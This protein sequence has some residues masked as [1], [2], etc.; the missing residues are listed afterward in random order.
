M[1]FIYRPSFPRTNKSVCV[2]APTIEYFNADGLKDFLYT[3]QKIQNG[4]LQRF[5]VPKGS[6]N[7]MIR[8]IWTPKMCLLERKTN[9]RRLHDVRYGLYERAVT[10]D[11]ADAYSNPDPVRGSILPGDIQYLCEQIVDHVMEVS[12]HK[13][14]ISRM[15]LHLK[16]DS[17]DKVWFLWSSSVRLAHAAASSTDASKPVDINSDAH[18]PSFVHLNI[19]P[20]GK[21]QAKL[22]HFTSCR[23]CGT[24]IESSVASTVTYKAILE[25]F[26]QLL[27]A[28]KVD[29]LRRPGP[30]AAMLWPPD[31]RIIVAAGGV[32]FGSVQERGMTSATSSAATRRPTIAK[33]ITEADVTIPPMLRSLHPHLTVDEFARFSHDPVF[34]YKTTAVCTDCFL[35]FADYSTSALEVNTLRQEAPA[36]LRPQREIPPLKQGTPRKH[37]PDSAWMPHKVP[38]APCNN[39][40]SSMAKSQYTFKT[41]PSLPQRIDH[42]TLDHV[43]RHLPPEVL[44]SSMSA[45]S[46][47]LPAAETTASHPA[48]AA[49]YIP[50]AWRQPTTM[51]PNPL[52]AL[53]S[54]KAL[55]TTSKED[56]FFAE[57]SASSM[58]LSQHH[59]LRHMVD[60]ASKL[61]T[62][63]SAIPSFT[64][65]SCSPTTDVGGPRK[66]AGPNPYAVV[67]TLRDDSDGSSLAKKAHK[68]PSRTSSTANI[69]FQRIAPTEDERV[70]SQKHREFLLQS[71]REIQEQMAS[72]DTLADVLYGT[73]KDTT[74]RRNLGTPD[75]K[76]SLSTQPEQVADL[77][78]ASPRATDEPERATDLATISCD[79]S[80]GMDDERDRPNTCDYTACHGHVDSARR[81]L[82]EQE[83]RDDGMTIPTTGVLTHRASTPQDEGFLSSRRTSDTHL[84]G[85]RESTATSFQPFDVDETSAELFVAPPDLDSDVCPVHDSDGA[86]ETSHSSNNVTLTGTTDNVD[87]D[88]VDGNA[89]LSDAPPAVAPPPPDGFPSSTDDDG[90]TAVRP[91]G[92][93]GLLKDPHD[94]VMDVALVPS[95]PP[96]FEAREP[97][98]GDTTALEL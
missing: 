69:S 15:V 72:P 17:N 2:D 23:S 84:S 95:S 83:Q 60:S 56:L 71:L 77:I 14:R 61:S 50:E 74:A 54:T 68:K 79:E 65:S 4:V 91:Q 80:K 81:S 92:P 32:G 3:R 27:H 35:V 46:L 22:R 42:T 34:L 16:T 66:K 87:S 1:T 49:P 58:T 70:T 98:H 76:Q 8:A 10:F 78:A 47:R 73:P 39:Q 11:G 85:R 43:Q 93:P 75:G 9:V 63:A 67:Q 37:L 13:H 51:V 88:P 38:S 90:P 25:H 7:S 64:P 40:H 59:P 41:P 29:M 44:R 6:C 30:T 28:M 24:S 89:P 62:A 26:R 21:P 5:V 36:V 57:L 12:F 48:S 53:G 33:P 20:D 82:D 31:E 18:V 19:M 97:N 45:P 94:V 55:T 52:A 86:A 96:T